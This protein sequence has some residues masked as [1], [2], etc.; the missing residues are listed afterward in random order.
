MAMWSKACLEAGGPGSSPERR[1]R[2]QVLRGG[3]G[4]KSREEGPG[5]SQRLL[6]S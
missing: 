1:A 3:P 2:V 5:L 6:T 4:F